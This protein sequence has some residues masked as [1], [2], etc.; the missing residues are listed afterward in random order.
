MALEDNTAALKSV[1]AAV[2]A[3]EDAGGGGSTSAAEEMVVETYT[4]TELPAGR[5]A[6]V[7]G[8]SKYKKFMMQWVFKDTS[9]SAASNCYM[10]FN[11]QSSDYV[12]YS[13]GYGT[14]WKQY[15]CVVVENYENSALMISGADGSSERGT[16]YYPQAFSAPID[17]FGPRW[18]D[19]A[20]T[21]I[22]GTITIYGVLKDTSVL[23]GV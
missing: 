1:L 11:E 5:T 21:T 22:D 23:E 14:A 8:L 7:S 18:L 4:I 12:I 15:A 17:K 3:L 9:A 19:S 10:C 20:I 6:I 16:M 13:L 2:N